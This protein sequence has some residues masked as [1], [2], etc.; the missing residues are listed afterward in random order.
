M[1][2]SDNGIGM[3]P[4]DVPEALA[5]F[6]QLD[7][8]LNRRRAG[9]GLGLALT[10]IL[11]ELHDDNFTFDTAKGAGTTVTVTFPPERSLVRYSEV[12]GSSIRGSKPEPAANGRGG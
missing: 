3:D 5:P 11:V 4:E 7:T 6:A 12:T 2:V 9:L 8:R 1:S 10:K